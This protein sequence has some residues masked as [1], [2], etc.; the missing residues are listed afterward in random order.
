MWNHP[1]S[2][3]PRIWARKKDLD[4]LYK[5]FA[6]LNSKLDYLAH[7]TLTLIA[8]LKPN[9][10]LGEQQTL[11]VIGFAEGTLPACTATKDGHV[12]KAWNTKADGTG[13]SFPVGSKIDWTAFNAGDE[14]NLYA[15]W[16]PVPYPI[17]YE[18]DGGTNDP[19]NPS[20][21]VYGVGV[22]SFGPAAKDGLLFDDWYADA[23]FTEKLS[24]IGPTDSGAKTLYAKFVEA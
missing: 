7:S 3:D 10:G 9:G 6:T 11:T 19:D 4:I 8:Y 1:G 24:S 14:M 18:L 5:K 2:P 12:C 16:T 21:Y 17:T 15:E 20:S 13:T 23:D 22:E